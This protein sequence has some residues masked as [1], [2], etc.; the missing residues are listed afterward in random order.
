MEPLAGVFAVDVAAVE[1]WTLDPIAEHFIATAARLL[2]LLSI[3]LG[4]PE[5]L[6]VH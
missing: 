5:H 6:T 1:I 2:G 3:A 4:T